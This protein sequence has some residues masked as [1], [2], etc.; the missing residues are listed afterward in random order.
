LLARKAMEDACHQSNPRS[1][2]E[3]DMVMLYERAL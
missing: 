1:C 3:A 2:A